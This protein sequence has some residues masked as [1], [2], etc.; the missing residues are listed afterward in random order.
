MSKPIRLTG[1]WKR[2][3]G[4]LSG[5]P[6]LD[7]M[8]GA[9]LLIKPVK[10]NGRRGPHFVAYLLT[11][12]QEEPEQLSLLPEQSPEDLERERKALEAIKRLEEMRLF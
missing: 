4:S 3:D 8:P 11:E 2:K 10:G 7:L 6:L 1:L 9:Q 5:G 12:D